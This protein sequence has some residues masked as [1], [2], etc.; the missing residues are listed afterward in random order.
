MFSLLE[1]ALPD[2][3]PELLVSVRQRAERD[4]ETAELWRQGRGSEAAARKIEDGVL[5]GRNTVVIQPAKLDNCYVC[6]R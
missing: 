5:H 2:R 6:H 1:K 3:I 4:R